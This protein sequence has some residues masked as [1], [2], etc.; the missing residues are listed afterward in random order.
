MMPLA[1]L[2]NK[3]ISAVGADDTLK[4]VAERMLA[5]R[6]GA[7]LVKQDGAYAGILS[8]TD[9]VRR[10]VAVGT[11]PASCQAKTV[12]SSPLITI[13]INQTLVEANQ[14]M[15]ESSIR[16][17]VVTERGDVVG[18]ISVRDLVIYFKNRI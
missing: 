5:D 4:Q 8:E 17:L 11:D 15:S 13:D 16:H 6:V 7:V 9:I 3:N 10:A 2:M 14:I 18:I 12:M 1:V